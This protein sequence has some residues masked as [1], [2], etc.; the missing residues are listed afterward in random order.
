MTDGLNKIVFTEKEVAELGH[1]QCFPY[2][3]DSSVFGHTLYTLVSTGTELARYT[4]DVF[5]KNPGYAA[6]FKVESVGTEVELVVP[7]DICFCIGSHQSHQMMDEDQVIV[8]NMDPKTVLFARIIRIVTD[9]IERSD[10]QLNSN[11]SVIGRGLVAYFAKALL[12]YYG[13]NITNEE[14]KLVLECTGKE[15]NVLK[16]CSNK[17]AEVYLIGTPWKQTS[18][19]TAHDILS[20]VFRNS[21]TLHSGWESIIED[22]EDFVYPIQ[23]LELGNIEVG[24][25]YNTAIPEDC[26]NVYQRLLKDRTKLTTIFDW[27]S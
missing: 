4:G 24:K 10:V 3:T 5:P 18:T 13:Y 12:S 8:V 15:A 1:T 11:V 16:A 7:G 17:D 23:L 9:V 27:R 26:Q 22:V 14:P 2:M 19:N 6:V 21:S 25:I 20:A